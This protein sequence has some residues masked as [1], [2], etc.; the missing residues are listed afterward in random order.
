MPT[1]TTWPISS[2]PPWFPRYR[3]PP[4]VLLIVQADSLRRQSRQ[5]TEK[6][7][8]RIGLGN[9]IEEVTL[10]VFLCKRTTRYKTQSVSR[11]ECRILDRMQLQHLLG[12]CLVEKR[13]SHCCSRTAPCTPPPSYRTSFVHRNLY[14]HESRAYLYYPCAPIPTPSFLSFFPLPTSSLDKLFARTGGAGR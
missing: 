14:T 8:H 10:H 3:T 1:C 5:L 12:L 11:S 6:G 13:R 7:C 2:S 4:K 9:W